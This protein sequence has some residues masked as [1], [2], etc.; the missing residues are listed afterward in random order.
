MIATMGEA[1]VDMI[2]QTD[3]RFQACL[4]GSVCNFTLGL[5]RQ[6]VTTAYLNPLSTDRF[7]ARFTN[8]LS[9]SEVNLA[10]PQQSSRPTSI[11]VV[12]LDAQGSPTYAFHREAIA[13]R[14]VS[15]AELIAGFPEQL[16]LLHTGGLALV[17]EDLEKTL[18]VMRA[19]TMR[20]ALVSIDAN[21]RPM[22]VKEVAEYVQGVKRAIAQ[23]HIVKVSVED[24]DALGI[25][26]AN[27]QSLANALFLQSAV[28]LIV[29]TRG[30][31]GAALVT[32][33]CQL[34]MAAPAGLQVT[35]TVG[36][37]DC[38]HAGLIAC[39]QRSGGLASAAALE[40]L[41]RNALQSALQHALAAASINIRRAG[42]DPASW[43]ET[44]EFK[45]CHAVAN[46]VLPQD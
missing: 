32:R 15:A 1:L 20:G 27:L 8:L 16:D 4:G 28:Q 19:A 46:D 35:D 3:G 2:E 21:V 18:A 30:A 13:D 26:S 40:Q 5:A 11:A 41:D 14:D 17:P 39:L 31:D 6:G 33:H 29:L 7:G 38:F 36:A 9:A 10:A 34:E 45:N 12:S 23:A 24:L 25:D 37:G 42:C 44:I 22:V 43:E